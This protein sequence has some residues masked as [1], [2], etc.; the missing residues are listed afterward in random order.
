MD[1]SSER[2]PWTLHIYGSQRTRFR[3]EHN[4]LLGGKFQTLFLFYNNIDYEIKQNLL[5]DREKNKEGRVV[6]IL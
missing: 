2:L 4:E 6:E 3:S 1:P 5:Y